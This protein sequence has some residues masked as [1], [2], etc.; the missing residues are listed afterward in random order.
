MTT[1]TDTET[2]CEKPDVFVYLKASGEV[3]AQVGT[4][5]PAPA[6]RVSVAVARALEEAGQAGAEHKLVVCSLDRDEIAAMQGREKLEDA[7]REVFDFSMALDRACGFRVAI[8]ADRWT[9]MALAKYDNARLPF[10]YA[11]RESPFVVAHNNGCWNVFS[12]DSNGHGDLKTLRDV[13][14]V[15]AATPQFALCIE[16]ERTRRKLRSSV[17]TAA[18]GVVAVVLLICIAVLLAKV[19]G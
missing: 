14:P 8:D 11:A 10:R 5:R 17:M 13:V 15:I 6:S 9:R 18:M 7:R 4:H 2:R 16:H 19:G 1:D 12:D 3:V